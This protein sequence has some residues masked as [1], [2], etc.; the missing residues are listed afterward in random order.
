[1]SHFELTVMRYQ[2]LQRHFTLGAE[3]KFIKTPVK[4]LGIRI[5]PAFRGGIRMPFPRWGDGVLD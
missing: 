3:R 1:M 2:W 5:S 4:L